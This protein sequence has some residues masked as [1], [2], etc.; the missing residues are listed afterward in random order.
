M[1][2]SWGDLKEKGEEGRTEEKQ[3]RRGGEGVGGG[4]EEMG[5]CGRVGGEARN[6]P[7]KKVRNSHLR[8][9]F[10]R[11]SSTIM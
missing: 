7:I 2:P 3:G 10:A 6:R 9:K 8:E 4:R 5:C 11:E 1:G